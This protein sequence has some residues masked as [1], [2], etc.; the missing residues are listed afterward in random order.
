MKE[1]EDGRLHEEHFQQAI[2]TLT[3]STST[4]PKAI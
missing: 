2:Y 1:A 3:G 4:Y